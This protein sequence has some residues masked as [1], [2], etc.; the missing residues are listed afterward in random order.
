MMRYI[1]LT[2]FFD[3]KTYFVDRNSILFNN[4]IYIIKNMKF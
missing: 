1:N 2:F 4:S 3:L